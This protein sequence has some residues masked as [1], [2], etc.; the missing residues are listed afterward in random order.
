MPPPPPI[1]CAE[2][3]ADRSSLVST[4]GEGAGERAGGRPCLYPHRNQEGG[5]NQSLWAPPSLP[6]L[7]TK[8]LVSI[9]SCAHSRGQILR[10]VLWGLPQKGVGSLH[11]CS[12]V[13][14][15]T[16]RAPSQPLLPGGSPANQP[17]SPAGPHCPSLRPPLLGLPP[18]TFMSGAS[19]PNSHFFLTH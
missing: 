5:W 15:A 16:C 3:R 11:L 10:R 9:T 12:G 4:E 18:M 19:R 1:S 17:S 14:R 8:A 2:Q 7:L 6:G 13:I